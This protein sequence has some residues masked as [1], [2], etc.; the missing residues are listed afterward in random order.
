[1]KDGSRPE[2]EPNDEA[3]AARVARRDADALAL[4]YDRYAKPVYAL[5]AHTLG[6]ADAEE[7]VQEVFLRLWN[8]ADQYDA[9]RGRFSTWFLAVARHRVLD[10]A[11][12]RGDRQR[13]ARA[14]E[15]DQLLAAAVDPAVDVEEA[16]WRRERSATVLRALQSL[17]KEQ[18]RVLV[19][20]YF[21]GFS[22]ATLAERL[23]WPLGTVK[24]RLRLGLQKLR[25]AL[26]QEELTE[27][28][29][30]EPAPRSAPGSAPQ[31]TSG[32]TSGPT[33]GPAPSGGR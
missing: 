3:L 5:A 4:L 30:I 25:I 16:A 15:V 2:A 19:L 10:E 8:K 22:Q 9:G 6:S 12:R 1:M 33:P 14:E 27:N 21:G 7:V 13:F 32:L 20:A 23:G 31:P 18:R 26:A 11:R 24:K 29:A 28:L 17:P